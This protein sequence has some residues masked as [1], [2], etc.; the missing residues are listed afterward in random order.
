MEKVT[1][2][3]ATILEGGGLPKGSASEEIIGAQ[4]LTI[5]M[6]GAE[7]VAYSPDKGKGRK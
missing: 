5:G 6:R 7:E 4:N 3:C 1:G 2:F